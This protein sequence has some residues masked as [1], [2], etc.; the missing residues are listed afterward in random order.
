MSHGRLARAPRQRVEEYPAPTG[1]LYKPL[2]LFTLHNSVP[3]YLLLSP[4]SSLRDRGVAIDRRRDGVVA[5]VGRRAGEVRVDRRH[6]PAAS[7]ERRW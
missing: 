7:Q 5:E 2:P 1:H 4:P 3:S 6:R